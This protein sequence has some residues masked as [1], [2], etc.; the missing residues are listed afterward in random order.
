M[1]TMAKPSLPKCSYVPFD[2]MEYGGE[3]TFNLPGDFW[4]IFSKYHAP[5][6]KQTRDHLVSLR[7]GLGWSRPR[8]AAFM[9]VSRETVR[10]WETNRR[11]PVG[12]ARRLIWLLDTLAF[13]PEKLKNG[14]DF[15]FWGQREEVEQFG[16]K[17]GWI[18]PGPPSDVEHASVS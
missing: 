9:G 15:I 10:R 8:L 4:L 14:L 17:F 16:K 7:R 18:D 13:H 11:K 3:P 1:G 6:A 5:S 12:A 2:V